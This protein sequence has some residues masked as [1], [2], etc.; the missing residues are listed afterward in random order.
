M[1]ETVQ[2]ALLFRLL[3]AGHELPAGF[4][5][6]HPLE[7][8]AVPGLD[9]RRPGA[10]GQL[11]WVALVVDPE[12]GAGQRAQVP[13]RPAAHQRGVGGEALRSAR[14]GPDRLEADAL[15]AHLL[16]D[17]A[18]TVAVLPA[19]V[20]L[21]DHQALVH[22]HPQ[23]DV[24]VEAELGVSGGH[25]LAQGLRLA[26]AGLGEAAGGAPQ[27][28]GDEGVR[29]LVG[30]EAEG[31]VA[32]G[33]DLRLDPVGDQPGQAGAHRHLT[34][35][36]IRARG[37]QARRRTLAIDVQVETHVPHGVHDAERA[38]ALRQVRRGLPG[39]VR[40]LVPHGRNREAEGLETHALPSGVE[41]QLGG[42]PGTGRDDAEGV[43]DAAREPDDIA[44]ALLPLLPVLG[45][46]VA[47]EQLPDRP[48]VIAQLGDVQ[49]PAGE[50]GVVDVLGAPVDPPLAL[51]VSRAAC[52]LPRRPR[53]LV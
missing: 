3:G 14:V 5:E 6:A 13:Q 43:G 16:V 8:G 34:G 28:A 38:Q 46:F 51:G 33:G 27:A 36:E 11:Q 40:A 7:R 1:V 41:L 24:A 50:G 48:G 15:P 25:L 49:D 4:V 52:G 22:R 37:G 20:A 17:R 32:A 26:V 18:G 12:L 42:E 53:P 39:H 47:Q 35:H 45:R 21:E 29:L 2:G 44:L 30:D 19:Q 9:V 10:L 31:E 23:E